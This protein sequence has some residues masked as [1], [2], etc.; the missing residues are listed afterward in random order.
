MGRA[1]IRILQ[2]TQ[3]MSNERR[4]REGLNQEGKVDVAG[5]AR[6]RVDVLIVHRAREILEWLKTR[7]QAHR[8]ERE[9]GS[10]HWGF[11]NGLKILPRLEQL[12]FTAGAFLP[13]WVEM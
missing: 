12:H 11:L 6:R 1:R 7:E 13:R 8:P 3:R 9:A 5:L 2:N 4:I 10:R